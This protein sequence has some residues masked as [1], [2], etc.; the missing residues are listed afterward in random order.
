M[1]ELEKIKIFT[2]YFLSLEFSA[3]AT[4][5]FK[6]FSD[7]IG[8]DMNN[9]EE[10]LKYEE[11]KCLGKHDFHYGHHYRGGFKKDQFIY[12][13]YAA[14]YATTGKGPDLS[15]EELKETYQ[16]KD[17]ME[18]CCEKAWITANCFVSVGDIEYQ[19][20]RIEKARK[21][22]ID[23]LFS[24]LEEGRRYWSPVT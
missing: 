15:P 10:F 8:L 14:I 4:R 21:K 17:Y 16:W 1:T 22:L 11:G 13:A 20:E 18:M 2:M 7:E 5:D 9:A 12:A 24:K 23:L 19:N 6:E 3:M